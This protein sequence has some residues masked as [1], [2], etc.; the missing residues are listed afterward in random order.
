[1]QYRDLKQNL[2]IFRICSDIISS[3]S[4][5]HGFR[6]SSEMI[7]FDFFLQKASNFM[8]AGTV[9][10]IVLSLKLNHHKQI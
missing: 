10:K 5:F 3:Y 2:S 9:T 8:A 1:V 6:L 7:I 4:L